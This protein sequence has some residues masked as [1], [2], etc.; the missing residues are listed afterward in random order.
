[1]SKRISDEEFIDAWNRLGSPS[2]VAKYLKMATRAAASRRRS[3]EKKY[4]ISLPSVIPPTSN[5]SKK[6]IVGNAITK[7]SEDRAR[8]YETEMHVDVSD[9]IVLIASDAHYWPQIVTP[10][11]KAF[12]K[13][14]KSLSPALVILNGDILDGAR[15]SRHP[16][17]LWEKQPELKEEI[18]AVQDRCAEIERASGKAKL[19]RTIGNHDARFENYLCTNAPEMEEMPGAM[20]LDYLPRWRAGWAV[21]VNAES[22]SWTVIRHRPVGGGIHAAYNSALRSGVNYVHGHLHKLQYT[23]WGD[24]R[25]R[26]YGVDTGTLAE[27][28]GP[29]FHYTE[30]GPLNWASGFAVLTF[31]DGRLLEPEM[32]VVINGQAYFRGQR[33]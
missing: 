20:L 31:R 14:V 10:A 5:T 7:L 27:P 2:A 21:H 33:V 13:L 12:C 11:H 19:I 15:I 23:P 30:A 16:R 3:M 25:G 28:K 8:R 1:M 6:T 26:R 29:Q 4:G 17:S 24:Y 9:A 22:E 32:C 18:H